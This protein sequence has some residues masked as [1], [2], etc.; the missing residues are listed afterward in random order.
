MAESLLSLGLPKILSDFGAVL[1]FYRLKN[2]SMV[3]AN[4]C[5]NFQP[6]IH[7]CIAYCG[8]GNCYQYIHIL[9]KIQPIN[10]GHDHSMPPSNTLNLLSC[11]FLLLLFVYRKAEMFSGCLSAGKMQNLDP[12]LQWM[13]WNGMGDE[14]SMNLIMVFVLWFEDRS[15]LCVYCMVYRSLIL[16]SNL[17]LL[18]LLVLMRRPF[19]TISS[20]KFLLPSS[21]NLLGLVVG[22]RFS[23]KGIAE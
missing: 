21:S 7:R 8:V 15:H 9:A 19:D 20:M 10:V 13:E 14:Q 1:S 6:S 16:T 11:C 2:R 17:R 22:F 23:M 5:I 18:Y 3:S 4:R 12:L